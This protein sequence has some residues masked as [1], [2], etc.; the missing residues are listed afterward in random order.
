MNATMD[1][2]KIVMSL[3][4]LE[5]RQKVHTEKLNHIDREI[6]NLKG[7]IWKLILVVA[8]ASAGGSTLAKVFFTHLP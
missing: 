5:E 6:D 7:N 3:S 2:D 1:Q 4:R 8:G